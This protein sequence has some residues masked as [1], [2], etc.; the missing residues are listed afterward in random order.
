MP[1]SCLPVEAIL[2][3]AGASAELNGE[4]P[5]TPR[6]GLTSLWPQET[7]AGPEAS[8]DDVTIEAIG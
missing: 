2:W 3:L 4:W 1:G 7:A 5:R 6:H 8:E